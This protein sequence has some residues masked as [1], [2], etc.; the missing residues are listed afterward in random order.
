MAGNLADAKFV[1][2]RLRHYLGDRRDAGS[3]YGA[4]VRVLNEGLS[5]M[6][7]RTEARILDGRRRFACYLSMEYLLGKLGVQTLLA[8]GAYDAFAEAAA[9]LGLRF[10][11]VLARDVSTQLGNGGLGRLAACFFDSV[12]AMRMPVFG[13]G[14]F[15]RCGIYRQEIINGRQVELPDLWW[16]DE[17]LAVIRRDGI[18]YSVGF[19]G[20]ANGLEWTPQEKVS[21]AARDV[22]IAGFCSGAAATVRL[23]DAERPDSGPPDIFGD[24][25]NIT[26]FLYPPDDTPAGKR[27]RLRQEYVLVCASVNDML[28]RFR[29]TGL[30]ASKID[31]YL[32]VQLNDTHPALAIPELIW[33]FMSRFGM[34]FR[35]AYEKTG[36]ICSYT[37]HTL[38]AE[39]LEKLD[40]KLLAAE[41][42]L[43]LEVIKMVSADFI[44]SKGRR[45]DARALAKSSI[46]SPKGFVSAGN[47]CV[48]ACRKVN[49]VAKLHSELLREREFRDLSGL[50]RG[51]FLN[52]TNGISPRRWLLE[53]NPRLAHMITGL[54]GPEWMA[55]LGRLKKLGKYSGDARVL[56]RLRGIKRENKAVLYGMLGIGADPGVMLDAQVKRIHE[57]KRQLLNILQVIH[58]YN[59]ICEGERPPP[60]VAL[61]A[62]KAP[63]TYAM[64]KEIL[65]LINGVA[66]VVN[67]DARARGLLHVAFVPNYN[68]DLAERIISAADLSEQVSLA[69]TEASGTGNMKFALNGALTIGTLDGANVEIAERVGRG[70]MFIFGMDAREV[71]RE[72]ARGYD[73]KRF[74]AASP[75]LAMVLARL[76][77]GAFGRCGMIL[78]ALLEKGDEYMVLADFASY[79]RAQER[80]DAV[81]ADWRAWAKSSLANIAGSGYFSSDRAIAGYAGD[82]WR[83]KRMK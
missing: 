10:D 34:D 72:R 60:R 29:A 69:G 14:L 3:A 21:V 68:I 9:E 51:K 20:R 11:D 16:R 81:Y 23:W 77:D 24:I 79:L 54:I 26:D 82:I 17:N 35:A 2:S 57:Y 75:G 4:M 48:I 15:Y 74:V 50:Y 59:R 13:Y 52:E 44:V 67:S 62:G 73:P 53:A 58:R 19:G 18:K 45:L 31:R 43:H 66:G 49:G 6:A 33:I 8:L 37:N 56:E 76:E 22:V 47:L 80:A 83:I 64:A 27:L 70:N 12:A 61:F 1:A 71:E 55:D 28:E 25:R 7:A 63:P 41:L 42:P 40:L 78:D 36:V 30:P 32:R 5:G 46:V 39:A 38:M 65:A